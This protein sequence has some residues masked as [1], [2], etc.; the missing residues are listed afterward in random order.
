MKMI[1]HLSLFAIFLLPLGLSAQSIAGTW[2]MDVPDENGGMAVIKATIGEDGSYAL[3]WGGD[4]SVEVKGKYEAKDG[5]MTIWDVEGSDCSGKGV[6]KYA[7]SG[8]TMT[9]TRIS[10]ACPDRGGPEGVMTMQ[11]G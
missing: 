4:G 2:K 5:Q 1:K 6:Y 7:I 10:D 11:R 9:M 8:N 3:D